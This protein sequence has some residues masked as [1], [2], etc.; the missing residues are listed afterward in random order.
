MVKLSAVVINS[1]NP[2][3]VI[4]FWTQ[5]LGVG[6]DFG[7]EWFSFLEARAGEPKL[8]VQTVEAPTEGRRRLHLDFSS[9]N[10]PADIER[11]I[12]LGGSRLEEH[13]IEGFTWTVMADPDGNEFCLAPE[14]A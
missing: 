9:S 8:A 7:N 12:S 4:E 3:P 2:K 11:V 13:S 10:V 5:F 6:V 1:A 14:H